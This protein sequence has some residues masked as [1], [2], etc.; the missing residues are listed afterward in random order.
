MLSFDPGDAAYLAE[1]AEFVAVPSISRDADRAQRCR[2]R[3]SGWP[4]SW[5]SRAA[6]WCGA[7]GHPV[8]LGSWSG[9]AGAPTVLVYGHYDVQPT[10]S[11][12]RVGDAAVRA[13]RGR[14]HRP[15][16]G[17]QRRQGARVPGA[18]DR[19]GLHGAG[20][21]A[22]AQREVPLRGRGGDRQPAPARFCGRARRRT[23]RRPG[24]LRRRGD[25]AAGR[26]LGRG[27]VQ[28]PGRDRHPRRGGQHGPAFR[29]VRRNCRQSPARAGRHPGQPAPPGRKGRRRRL[30]RRH[31]RR[32]VRS[33]AANSRRSPSTNR[34]ISR[35]WDWPSRTA[36]RGS[37]RWSACGSGPRWR[38]TASAAAGSTP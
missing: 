2:R 18:Q 20:G 37:P 4:G 12:G 30:L 10:G 17:R 6:G 36:S 13:D 16:P 15:R 23:G 34:A 31:S 8:V 11:R 29:T 26:A 25:V 7:G 19:A 38:S 35:N 1:L 3:R 28:G 27:E 33:A 24:H 14:R 5:R 21:P 9:A 22:A 32:S